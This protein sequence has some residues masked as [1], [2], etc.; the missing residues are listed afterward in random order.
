MV[1]EGC[2][3]GRYSF[4]LYRT[5]DDMKFSI[6]TDRFEGPLDLLIELI[7]K[8]KLL[9]N[10][11]SIAQVTDEYLTYVASLTERSLR[12]A[13]QFVTLASTLLLIKSRSLLP[14]LEVTQDEKDAME[15]LEGKLRCY[16]IYRNAG[17]VLEKMF[18]KTIV[19]AR[20][21]TPD[22]TPI[23]SPDD[24]CTKEALRDV[25]GR[26]LADLPRQT[27]LPQAHVRKT[28]SLEEM[29]DTLRARLEKQLK[30]RFHDLSSKDADKTTV[31][32]SF[33]AVLEL[34]RQ[35]NVNVIQEARFGDIDITRE[36]TVDAVPRY[37]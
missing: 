25:I 21:F 23:F 33:L 29:M 18:G 35:G 20:P 4:R 15:D 11:F 28:I 16:Q 31:V 2:A 34:F 30:V 27:M 14:V 5:N 7:E 1:L 6:K 3:A 19:N 24:F 32:V 13:A 26:V 17:K 9:I 12:D 22:T 37:M 8:R 10:D 36:E